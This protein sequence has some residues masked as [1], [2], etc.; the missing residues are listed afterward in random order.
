MITGQLASGRPSVTAQRVAVRRAAHQ[1]LDRPLVFDDPVAVRIIGREAGA[2]LFTNP[3]AGA[4]GLDRYFRAFM[5]ARSRIAEDE[6]AAAVRRGVHQYVILGAGLDTFAYRNPFSPGTLRVFEVDHPSTQV[7][8][9][10][11]LSEMGIATPPDLTFA[12]IDFDRLTLAEGLAA[13]GFDRLRPAFFSWLGV[14]HYLADEVVT[15]TL[16][17][18]ASTPAGGGGV[19]DY[20]VTP[21]RANLLARWIRAAIMRRVAAAGEPW[22]SS[23]R[24]SELTERL[25][26]MGFSRVEDL[27]DREINARYFGGR[28]DGLRVGS[29]SRVMVL[30]T[31]P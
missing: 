6:L 21:P 23:F 27:G 11:R 8:K 16:E 30:E 31:G 29:L 22:R 4:G 20:P 24:P 12:P 25:K 17:F 9:R 2:R 15:A 5:A 26:A 7:W 3:Y 19:F 10:A 18:I 14:T 13:A 1:L 28:S